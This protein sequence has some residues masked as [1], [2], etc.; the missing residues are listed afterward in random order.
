[1]LPNDDLNGQIFNRLLVIGAGPKHPMKRMLLCRCDCGVEKVI[2]RFAVIRGETKSCGCW[3]NSSASHIKK[4]GA[5]TA[6]TETRTYASWRSLRSRCLNPNNP[7]S[8][9]Y[10]GR[11]ITVCDR[12][13]SFEAFVED[14]GERPQGKSIDRIDNDGNYCPENCKWSTP[15]EQNRVHR[16]RGRK[17]A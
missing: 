6:G 13:E 16:G 14:M 12:W 1:M 5:R 8:R 9:R 2:A 11:G 3:K 7:F 10:G 17:A 4:H 15:H